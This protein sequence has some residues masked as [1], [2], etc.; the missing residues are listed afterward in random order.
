MGLDGR[1]LARMRVREEDRVAGRTRLLPGADVEDVAAQARVELAGFRLATTDSALADALAATGVPVQRVAV[2]MVHD[3][4]DVPPSAPLPRGW[5]LA[6]G[7]WDADLATA[8]VEAYGSGH[9]DGPWTDE[10]SAEMAGIYGA[11][12]ALPPLS[13]ATARVLD[14]DRRSAG[15][16]LCAGPVPWTEEGAWI[17]TVGLARRAQGQGLGRALISHAV[18]GAREAGQPRLGLSVTEGNPARRL[19]DAAGFT[20]VHRVHSFRLPD[21]T[22][23]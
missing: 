22:S 18:R 1:P 7:G 17:L 20:V 15:H 2:D 16:I 3:L 23:R 6:P 13:A 10:N 4:A 14:P 5:T 12:A 11:G 19:Y 9:V 21:A 8:V